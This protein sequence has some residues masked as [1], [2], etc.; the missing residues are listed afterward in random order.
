MK[1]LVRKKNKPECQNGLHPF[2]EL[3]PSELLWKTLVFHH[4]RPPPPQQ[5]AEKWPD[6]GGTAGVPPMGSREV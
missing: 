3:Q 4:P 5:L 1:S 6:E 2:N